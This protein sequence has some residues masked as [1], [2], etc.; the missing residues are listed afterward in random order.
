MKEIPLTLQGVSMIISIFFSG[1]CLRVFER[2]LRVASKQDFTY[3]NSFWN[4]VVTMTTVGYGDFYP[5]TLFGRF[6]G[7]I[8]CFWGVLIVSIFVVSLTNLLTLTPAEEKTYS[9]L[10]RL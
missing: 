5:K 3:S 9:L 2:P 7:I 1:F 4:A 10:L 6:I 8:I